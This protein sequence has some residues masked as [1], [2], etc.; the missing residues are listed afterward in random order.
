MYKVQNGSMIEFVREM[1]LLVALRAKRD[2]SVLLKEPSSE[3]NKLFLDSVDELFSFAE[4]CDSH[5]GY[6]LQNTS[7]DHV[8]SIALFPASSSLVTEYW[9]ALERKAVQVCEDNSE[10]LAELQVFFFMRWINRQ[11]RFD[12][13]FSRF[14]R[15]VALPCFLWPSKEEAIS[16][17]FMARLCPRW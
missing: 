9:L 14:V 5:Y 7:L 6:A 1:S 13:F 8:V 16:P 15:V 2:F 10:I 17:L 4:L 12:I 11:K 3:K